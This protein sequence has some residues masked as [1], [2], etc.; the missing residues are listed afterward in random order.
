M[1]KK[2]DYK[3]Q[4]KNI[5]RLPHHRGPNHK[6]V[7]APFHTNRMHNAI[8]WELPIGEPIYSVLEGIVHD[9]EFWHEDDGKLDDKWLAKSNYVVI[10]H[11]NNEF[12]FYVH[13]KKDSIR[14]REGQIVKENTKI[15]QIGLSGYTGYPHLHFEV[16][17]ER[18]MDDP[19]YR[20]PTLL[21][22]F[23][24]RNRIF[25]MRSDNTPD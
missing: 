1:A 4:S 11:E 12:S 22:R 15:A 14:V 13:L 24:H 19:R 16:H 5:Y 18:E 2:W 3:T 20:N 9:V 10:E 8:D 25:T 6:P 21:T 23:K 17:A 7:W